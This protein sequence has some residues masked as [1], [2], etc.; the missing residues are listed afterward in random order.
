MIRVIIERSIPFLEH[1]SLQGV[2]FIRLDNADFTAEHI[3]S[4]DALIVRSITKC[5]SALL[6]GSCVRLIATATAGTDHIDLD[7]CRQNGIAVYSAAGC[8]ATAVAQWVYSALSTWSLERSESLSGKTIGIVGIGHVGRE[9]LRRCEAFGLRPL[10]CDPPRAKQEG[11]ADFVSLNEIAEQS[12]IITLHT[13][14]TKAG[15]YPT[16]H[17]IDKAFIASCAKS[18]VLINASRGAVTDTSAL[19]QG[20]RSGMLRDLLIDCWEGEPQPNH[21]LLAIAHTATPHI[22]GFSADGKL[23]GSHMCIDA[24]CRFF[25]LPL[26][27][28]LYR[29]DLLDQPRDG[30]LSVSDTEHETALYKAMLHTLNLGPITQSLK[31][32]P[33]TFETLRRTYH[34]PREMSAHRYTPTANPKLAHALQILG[35]LPVSL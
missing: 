6:E 20:Y 25:S 30:V 23:R 32:S 18:P 1:I 17:L 8:N 21:D 35:F 29:D 11:Q 7:Y 5:T 27:Q 28:D 31:S 9:V 15:D 22:A 13:P 14:L 34:Y 10:L 33:E 12:D 26:P 2:E 3:R 4:A 16:H 19:I 24:L